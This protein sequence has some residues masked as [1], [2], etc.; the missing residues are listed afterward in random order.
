VAGWQILTDKTQLLR[1]VFSYKDFGFI[2]Q[3][4]SAVA[5]LT[6]GR[7]PLFSIQELTDSK[8]SCFA[9]RIISVN[10]DCAFAS[11]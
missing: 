9:H 4:L 5:L 1:K 6:R 11:R 7:H 2:C 10:V 8:D 3:C